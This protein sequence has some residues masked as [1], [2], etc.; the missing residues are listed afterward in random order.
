[1]ARE[2]AEPMYQLIYTSEP[3]VAFSSQ[4]IREL[5]AV[6]RA[7]NRISLITGMLVFCDRQFL[8]VLEGNAPDVIRTYDRIA[9]DVRH[10]NLVALH[11]GYSHVGKTFTGMAMGFHSLAL[12]ENLPAGFSRE[13]GRVNFAHFDGLQ[14]LEFLIACREQS[15]FA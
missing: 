2:K 4:D 13:D 5:L 7:R 1:M 14:A 10:D 6:A 15:A 3:T 11:R 12:N 9:A 8:Q